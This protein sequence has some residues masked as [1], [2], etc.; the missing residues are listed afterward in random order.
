MMSVLAITSRVNG[1]INAKTKEKNGK[2][3]GNFGA[4]TAE[5]WA[6]SRQ[7]VRIIL[8][9]GSHA[10]INRIMASETAQDNKSN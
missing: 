3:F 1:K 7:D 4:T 10:A 8:N 2:I 6:T 5:N 9:S